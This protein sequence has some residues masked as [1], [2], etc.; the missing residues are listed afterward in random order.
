MIEAVTKAE[1]ACMAEGQELHRRWHGQT[2]GRD[3]KRLNTIGLTV[4]SARWS[5]NLAWLE[6]ARRYLAE[7]LQHHESDIPPATT[8]ASE[9]A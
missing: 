4:A 7:E 1:Q 8:R 2:K 6:E 3:R 5:K 9:P